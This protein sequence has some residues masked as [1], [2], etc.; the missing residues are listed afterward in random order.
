LRKQLKFTCLAAVL[1]L[2]AGITAYAQD[3]NEAVDALEEA[4]AKGKLVACADPF[5]YPY[6]QQNMDP[7]G[8]DVEIIREL[9]KRGGMRVE[10]YWADTSSHGGMSKALRR[11][12]MKHRCDIFTGVSDSGDDDILMGKLAFS[13]PYIGLGYVLV[14][15]NKA[16]DMRTIAELKAANI[17]IGVSMSTPADGYLFD[18]DIPRELYFGNRRV[19]EGLA[20]GEVDAA[21]VWATAVPVG[22]QEHPDAKFD[23]VK[24]YV[25]VEG[26]RWDLKYIVRKRDKSLMKFINEGIREL[27]DNGKIK[28]IVESYGVPFYAPFSS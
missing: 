21:M 3:P 11:S 12:M 5:S 10:M 8:F 24:D 2:H 15:E 14:V 22:K 9:A 28:E 18:H 20:K 4:K 23:M 27:L 6:A 19:M 25:P 16:K 13:D 17:K 7:P 26:Q 1:A